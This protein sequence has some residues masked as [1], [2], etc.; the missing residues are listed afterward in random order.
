MDAFHDK[1]FQ[2]IKEYFQ[3]RESRVPQKY[4]H[5]V[6]YYLDRSINKA[7]KVDCVW[8]GEGEYQCVIILNASPP[9]KFY[10]GYN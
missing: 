1:G 6:F 3:Q 7:S 10:W 9:P 4:N 8:G 5:L 2:K